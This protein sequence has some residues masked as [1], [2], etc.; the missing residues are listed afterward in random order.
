MLLLI[1]DEIIADDHI[2]DYICEGM[3]LNL[4]STILEGCIVDGGYLVVWE[5]CY[6]P[7]LRGADF[8]EPYNSSK[9]Q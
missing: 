4:K 1:C 7:Q 6:P 9:R 8:V 3:Q 5:R 2:C